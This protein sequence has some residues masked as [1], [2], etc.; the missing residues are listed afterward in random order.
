MTKSFDSYA[1]RARAGIDITEVSGRYPT[2]TR[3]ERNIVEDVV[4]KLTLG[5]DDK[6][7]EVG[8]GPGT[9]LIPLAF[10]CAS[11]TGVDNQASLELLRA[12]FAGPPTITTVPGNFL[13]MELND[14]YDAILIYGVLHVLPTVD[15]VFEFV[16]RA[17]ACLAP[18]GRLL[19]GDLANRD[20]RARFHGSPAGIAF[21]RE[22]EELQAKHPYTSIGTHDEVIGAFDDET[23]ARL[24]CELRALGFESYLLPQPPDLPFGRTR[25]DVLV[26]AHR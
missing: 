14:R 12:R 9:L 8:C 4:A 24:L 7:L 21:Q 5:P 1:E 13:A 2:Q 16:R 20:K 26:H 10:R 18:G 17:T 6:L 23:I 25:E 22:W 11:A 15:D 19:L 3:D